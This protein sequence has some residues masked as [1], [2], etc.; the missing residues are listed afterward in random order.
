MCVHVR[1][2]YCGYLLEAFASTCIQAY[3]YTLLKSISIVSLGLLDL[4]LKKNLKIPFVYI[5]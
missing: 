3:T 1:V 4:F 5:K 2:E